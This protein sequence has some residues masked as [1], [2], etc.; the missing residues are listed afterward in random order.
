MHFNWFHAIPGFTENPELTHFFVGSLVTLVLIGI[1]MFAS[2]VAG[3]PEEALV[4]SPHFSARG[5]FEVVVE[6]L[7]NLIHS[8]IG[9]GAQKFV[10]LLGSLFIYILVNNFT[11]LIP[12][13][14][15]A[16]N[17]MNTA[18][19][20]GL[21]V[22]VIYNYYGFKENGL[23]YLK[24]MMGPV[25]YLAPLIFVIEIISHLV[26]PLS[27]GL[28][29][30]QNMSGDHEVLALFLG[31]VPVGVP[32]VFYVLGMFVCFVQAFVFTLL[33]SVYISMATA[34]DH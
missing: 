11:G 22:F 6:S 8:I 10:P 1:S 31:L 3:K 33:S 21:C 23:G 14:T 32:M 19:A 34:H 2:A 26:R 20:V 16:T 5:F 29:L 25:W 4:P 18:L 15:P 30:S 13:M 12:G 27:L 7:S 17:N 9:D 24:H 28:R